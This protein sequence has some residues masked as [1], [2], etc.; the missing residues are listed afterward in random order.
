MKARIV[1][2]MTH[3]YSVDSF[4]GLPLASWLLLC[5]KVPAISWQLCHTLHFFNEVYI[6]YEFITYP[7]SEIPHALFP[8]L[9]AVF[10]GLH[11]A[12]CSQIFS[13]KKTLMRESVLSKAAFK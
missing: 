2:C 11:D 12:F 10:L 6:R 9:S 1:K 7:C 3:S 13:K 5:V 4:T 8:D